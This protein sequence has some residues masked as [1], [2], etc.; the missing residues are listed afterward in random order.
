MNIDVSYDQL[1]SQKYLHRSKAKF[2]AMFG[3]FGSGKTKWLCRELIK[4][5]VDNEGGYCVMLRKT[6][7][8][9]DDTLLTDFFEEL[10]PRLIKKYAPA[11]KRNLLLILRPISR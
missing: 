3:G 2:K 4:N 8:E 1:P 7:P 9:L 5:A 10:D 11:P 6:Y